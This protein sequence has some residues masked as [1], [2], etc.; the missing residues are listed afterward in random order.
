MERMEEKLHQHETPDN[1]GQTSTAVR[2]RGGNGDRGSEFPYT[3]ET[4]Y[5]TQR[6]EPQAAREN[7]LKRALKS[8]FLNVTGDP[9]HLF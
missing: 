3:D 1:G 6:A 8:F 5:A 7:V 2:D 4:L 9:W